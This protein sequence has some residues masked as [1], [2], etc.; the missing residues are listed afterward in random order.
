MGNQ[1][2]IE[3]HTTDVSIRKNE[4]GVSQFDQAK[5]HISLNVQEKI[6]IPTE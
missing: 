4:L 3:K 2:V 5:V 6:L 1:S